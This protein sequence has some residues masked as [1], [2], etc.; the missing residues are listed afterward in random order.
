MEKIDYSNLVKWIADRLEPF[1][2]SKALL[3]QYCSATKDDFALLDACLHLSS[4]P[5]EKIMVLGDAKIPP[6]CWYAMVVLSDEGDEFFERGIAAAKVHFKDSMP[7][8]VPLIVKL[9][10]VLGDRANPKFIVSDLRGA[11]TIARKYS[12]LKP[13]QAKVFEKMAAYLKKKGALTPKQV[14]YVGSL[15]SQMRSA[16]VVGVA[17]EEVALLERLYSMIN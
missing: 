6:S 11:A 13:D 9:R 3:D 5:D 12:A 14:G 1:R 2:R 15:L 8:S 17:P 4:L 7:T 10:R 16:R